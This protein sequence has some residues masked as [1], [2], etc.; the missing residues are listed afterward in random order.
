[1]LGAIFNI[2]DMVVT[3]YS[4]CIVVYALLSW[5]PGAYQS[6]FGKFITKLV[7]PY[8]DLFSR[9]PLQIAGIDFSTI[10]ALFLLQFGYNGLIIL[11]NSFIQ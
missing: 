4:Y 10:A 9:L 2:L 5:F 11:V 3:I 6:S 1:M 8:L 7:R